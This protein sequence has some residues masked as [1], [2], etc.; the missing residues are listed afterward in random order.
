MWNN[1][2]NDGTVSREEAVAYIENKA[3]EQGIGQGFKVYYQGNEVHDETQLPERVVLADIRV[4][5][6]LNQASWCVV[7]GVMLS[8]ADMAL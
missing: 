1:Q 3:N 2:Q 7:S 6:S 5:A 4:S 8:P